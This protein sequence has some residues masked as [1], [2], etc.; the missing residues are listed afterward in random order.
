MADISPG[1]RLKHR[2][3]FYSTYGFGKRFGFG[4]AELAFLRWAIKRGVFDENHGSAWWRELNTRYAAISQAAADIFSQRQNSPP[5]TTADASQQAWLH[6][7]QAPSFRSWYR[8]HTVT[9]VRLHLELR[10]LAEQEPISEQL[11]INVQLLR[12][13]AW[14]LMAEGKLA[15]SSVMDPLASFA[16]QVIDRCV[17]EPSLYPQHYP[18]TPSEAEALGRTWNVP[19]K[20]MRTRPRADTYPEY[21]DRILREKAPHIFADA[22]LL[23][24]IPELA[25]FYEHE[26]F[27]YPSSVEPAKRKR[28]IVIVGGGLGGL[29]SAYELTQ[30]PDW[31]RHYDITLY[32]L[33]WRLGGKMSG[34]RGPNERIEELGLHLLLGFYHRAFRLFRRV[35]AERQQTRLAPNSPYQTLESALVPNRSLLFV[36]RDSHNQERWKNWTLLVPKKEGMAGQN[37]TGGWDE[38]GRFLRESFSYLPMVRH[39]VGILRV[40]LKTWLIL[41]LACRPLLAALTRFATRA[42]ELVANSA[43]L[44]WL[45][46]F[47]WPARLYM[48]VDVYGAIARGYFFDALDAQGRINEDKLRDIDF[49]DWLAKHGAHQRHLDSALV[50][51]FYNAPFNNLASDSHPKGELATS[52]ALQ[53]IKQ[54]FDYRG[55]IFYQLRLGTADTLVMPLYQVLKARGV[56]FEFFHRLDRVEG[57]SEK[58]S[59]LRFE[60][61]ARLAGPSYDPIQWTQDGTPAWPASPHFDQLVEEH[62]TTARQQHQAGISF[63]SPRYRPAKPDLIS[64]RQGDDFD[65]VILAVPPPALRSACEPLTRVVAGSPYQPRAQRWSQLLSEVRSVQVMSAQFYFREDKETL[66]LTAQRFGLPKEHAAPN[67]VTYAEPVFSWLDQTHFAVHDQRA[68]RPR[69][70]AAFTNSIADDPAFTIKHEQARHVMKQWFA[71]YWAWFTPNAFNQA[72]ELVDESLLC[73]DAT[74]SAFN[75]Q[76][77]FA[78]DNPSDRYITAP[79][80]QPARARIRPEESGFANLFL[81]GDWTDFGANFGYME[82]TI[83]SANQAVVALLRSFNRTRFPH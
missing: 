28:K 57:E 33:G 43:A 10:E 50:R 11:L 78:S 48:I 20:E 31:S 76:F 15:L 63:E 66:G 56:R 9:V 18:C 47:D 2:E 69:F 61:Q 58:I 55:F 79:P 49:R 81:A 22:A 29:T 8:A 46:R 13:L 52:T 25:G 64:L 39:V 21:L 45:W 35:Y 54:G 6:Y 51:F 30:Q 77:F 12:L 4:E 24:G 71:R 36:D 26:A 1:A 16:H 67:V 14:Q 80:G 44:D 60:R 27:T 74:K 3:Q 42:S 34:G 5:N 37:N 73:D 32:Q 65:A 82:G 38:T 41:F 7:F 53:F 59:L 40:A 68:V 62:A 17:K 23:L 72:G 19:E 70:V 75:Q 83:E